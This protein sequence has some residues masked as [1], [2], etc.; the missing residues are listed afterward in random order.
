MA[1]KTH[2]YQVVFDNDTRMYVTNLNKRDAETLH[3]ILSSNSVHLDAEKSINHHGFHNV[4]SNG[5]IG[6]DQDCTA[7]KLLRKVNQ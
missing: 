1:K 5:W 2:S 7:A 3:R 4:E 6:Y